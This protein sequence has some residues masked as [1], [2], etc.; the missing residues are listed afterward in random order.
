VSILARLSSN[1]WAMRLPDMTEIFVL[2][3]DK[4]TPNKVAPSGSLLYNK[5]SDTA[6]YT[7]HHIPT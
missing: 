7:E 6:R 2:S 4:M 1:G 5:V 3:D